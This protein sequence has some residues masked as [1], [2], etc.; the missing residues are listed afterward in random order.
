[1]QLYS[2]QSTDPYLPSRY[3]IAEIHLAGDKLPDGRI[4]LAGSHQIVDE[5]PSHIEVEGV[6]YSLED[7]LQNEFEDTNLM[8]GIYC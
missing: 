5:F 4:E 7:T 1:M 2:G 8:W 6:V 3:D